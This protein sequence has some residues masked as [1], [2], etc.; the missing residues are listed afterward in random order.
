M[1]TSRK[2]TRKAP[3]KKVGKAIAL[4]PSDDLFATVADYIEETRRALIRQASSATVYEARNL[5]RMMQFAEQFPDFEI[6]S[7]P[8]TQL[9]WAHVVEVLPLKTPEARLFYLN[10]AASRRL[11]RDGL[12]HLIARKA[13]ER[14]EIANAQL[15]ESSNIPPDTFK[16]P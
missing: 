11:G 9:S 8:A 10:E 14:K 15:P 3:A 12:R 6:V 2:T 1:A 4:A 13:F 5:R 7:R 16:D